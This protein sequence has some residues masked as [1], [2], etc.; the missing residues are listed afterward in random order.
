MAFLSCRSARALALAFAM[1]PTAVLATG[2]EPAQPRVLDGFE[3]A[4]PWRVVASNQVTG[5][6]RQVDGVDGKAL[7]LDYD[8]NDVSG[9]IG[10]QPDLPLQF[11][12][13]YRFTI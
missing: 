8:F 4:A 1:A 11:P 6:L 2:G 9:Y 5:S 7:C 10:L 13:N 12:E 3:D